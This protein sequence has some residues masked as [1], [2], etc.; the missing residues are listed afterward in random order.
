MAFQARLGP[1]A[2]TTRSDATKVAPAAK[3]TNCIIRDGRRI[4]ASASAA[5]A[6]FTEASI[7]SALIKMRPVR[8]STSA[9]GFVSQNGSC[10]GGTAGYAFCGRF[11]SRTPEPPFSVDTNL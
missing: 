4:V 8:L 2:N 10:R 5:R 9:I 1:R 7:G 3:A 6:R 11:F